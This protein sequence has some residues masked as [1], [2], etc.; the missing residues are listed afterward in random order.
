MTGKIHL[1]ILSMCLWAIPVS[2]Q[3]ATVILGEELT[4]P[5][6]IGHA[7]ESNYGIRIAGMQTQQAENNVTLSPFLPSVSGTAYQDQSTLNRA[8]D[9]GPRNTLNAGLSLNWTLFDGLN[10][11]S[12]Y[13]LK[14]ER[15]SVSELQMR[16]ELEVLVSDIMKQYYYLI[17]LHD[18]V[19]LAHESIQ[20]SQE[21]YDDA[22]FKYDVGSSSGLEMR[23]A[24][25][26]LNADSTDMIRKE[27]SLRQ[28]YIEMNR[29]IN[30]SLDRSY[31]VNDTILLRGQLDK[32]NLEKWTE[33]NNVSLL[34]ARAGVRIADLEYKIAKSTRYPTLGFAVGYNVNASDANNFNGS[35]R[36]SNGVNW[37]FSVGV[38]IFNGLETRRRVKNA[39]LERSIQEMTVDDVE[40]Y[41]MSQL[42]KLY[43][44]YLNNLQLI[45]F[46]HE[47]ADLARLNMETA[48]LRYRVG[49][50]SGIDLRNIQQ[51]YLSAVERKIKVIYEAKVS[52]VTLLTLA[53]Q[54]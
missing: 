13:R 32:E 28:A 6:L 51:Q 30:Q 22:L 37:G 38:N 3:S 31:Y 46:E 29:L 25:I 52:E 2:A 10:M 41:L 48:M 27:E 15:L 8:G 11:F 47:N 17:T 44:N 9:G 53:G 5:D 40:L 26:D 4:L 21:R 24:K 54:L 45:D 43:L 39:N 36:Q 7:I 16:S 42:D 23:L 35:F 12:D 50:L 1:L 33:G 20:L 19:E 18:Q 34:L 49:D 14:K